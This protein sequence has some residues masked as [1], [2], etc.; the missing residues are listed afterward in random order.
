VATVAPSAGLT[1]RRRA[2]A[3][4][5]GFAALAIGGFVWSVS[6]GPEHIG[7]WTLLK[8]TLAQGHDTK[9]LIV[10]LI[11]LPRALLAVLAGGA[12][13]VAGAMTQTLT[14]NPLGSPEILGVTS[15]AAL[16]V[17]LASV[18]V[19][20]LAGVE[21][22][23]LSIA[24]GSLAAVLVF[25]IARF[26]RGGI[27]PIRLTLAGITISLLAL[28]LLQGILIVFSQDAELFFFW[29][30][31]G[32]TYAS[33]RDI[34]T[35]YPWLLA[36]LA[37]AM[38]LARSLNGLALGD[39]V[40]RGLGYNVGRARWLSGVCVVL[41]ACAAVG[42]VGPVAFLGLIAP[43]IVRRV[44]GSHNHFVVL[45][46]SMMAG[47]ALLLYADIAARH[48]D[49]HAE[50]PAGVVV[51]PLGALVFIYLARREKVAI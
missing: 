32:V 3:V 14:G 20:G 40:A 35:V 39:E 37:L 5:I 44:T 31:G 51:A 30:V 50:I 9:Q 34:H 25:G 4:F 16:S 42:V 2:W 49:R 15:G 10:H 36:G 46:L 24:G 47:S 1:R 28:A 13:A 27:S 38:L 7:A 8:G 12:L 33:W 22:I 48:L 17:A 26:A 18:I 6:I 29:L 43:H 41:L 23:F 19:P 21:T 11:R 45:P